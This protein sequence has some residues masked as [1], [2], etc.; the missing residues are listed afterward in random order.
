MDD[1]LPPLKSRE[2]IIHA[3]KEIRSKLRPGGSLIVSRHD[4]RASETSIQR[5][6]VPAGGPQRLGTVLSLSGQSPAARLDL[7]PP[8]RQ[9]DPVRKYRAALRQA[10]SSRLGVR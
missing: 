7:V 4:Q 8:R 10:P 9:A 1:A 3:A 2:E 5:W 6:G